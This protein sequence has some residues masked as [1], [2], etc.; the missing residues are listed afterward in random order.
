M[1]DSLQSFMARIEH[2]NCS[3]DDGSRTQFEVFACFFDLLNNR[4]CLK[5]SRAL[6]HEYMTHTYFLPYVSIIYV[7]YIL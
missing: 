4:T 3:Y 2:Y 7:F 1:I 6:F 5:F